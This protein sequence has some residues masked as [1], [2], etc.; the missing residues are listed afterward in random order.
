MR[1]RGDT[2]ADNRDLS[3]TAYPWAFLDANTAQPGLA[4]Q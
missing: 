2:A 3:E 1:K 4:A